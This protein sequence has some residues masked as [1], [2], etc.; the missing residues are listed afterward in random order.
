V[1][2][3]GVSYLTT[4]PSEAQIAGITYATVTAAERERT[5]A[6]WNHWDLLATCLVLAIIASA[7]VYFSVM[8]RLGLRLPASGFWLLASDF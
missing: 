2:L 5:R 4:P 1:V 7:Y 8:T 6:S 3:I